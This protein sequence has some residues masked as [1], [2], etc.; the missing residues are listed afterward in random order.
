LH[1]PDF[2]KQEILKADGYDAEFKAEI[3]SMQSIVGGLV[4]DTQLPLSRALR[5]NR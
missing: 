1:E 5:A 4:D 2:I 3:E